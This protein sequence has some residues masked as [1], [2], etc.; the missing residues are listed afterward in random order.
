MNVTTKNQGGSAP[1][2]VTEIVLSTD[3]VPGGDVLLGAVNVPALGAGTSSTGS[4]TVTIPAITVAGT[5][6]LIGKANANGAVD[7]IDT[8]N[9]TRARAIVI[10]PDLVVSSFSVPTE[11][12]AGDTITVSETTKN[13]GGGIAPASTTRYYLSLTRVLDSS[14]LLIGSRPV[15][16]LD[17]GAQSAGQ[18]PVT[19]PPGVSS[20]AY[21]IIAQAD[22]GSGVIEVDEV[23][24]TRHDSIKIGPDL[25]IS[26]LAAPTTAVAG[27]IIAVTD[28]TNNSGGGAAGA[29]NVR[30]YL[31]VDEVLSADDV[32]VGG[33]LAPGVAANSTNS[34]SSSVTIPGGTAAGTY[35]LIGVTD[36]DNAISELNETNNQKKRTITIN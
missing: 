33:R 15:G 27:A 36:A 17:P 24:N 4:T 25:A 29:F 21:F 9:N 26:S 16:Q 2:S 22:G 34:G 20:A 23:N 28:T 3:D 14:A 5:Y 35:T 30:V 12:G 8:T 32:E 11:A 13:T 18:F 1:A 31:S 7:E 19:I 6:F 10:G